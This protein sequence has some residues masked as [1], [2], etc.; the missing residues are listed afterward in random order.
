MSRNYLRLWVAVAGLVL[1]TSSAII[2][3]DKDRPKR[4]MPVNAKKA[5]DIDLDARKAVY[6]DDAYKWVY[7]S[8]KKG[9][10]G[11]WD[12]GKDGVEHVR[13]G[14]EIYVVGLQP[15]GES[16]NY[17][18]V[19]EQLAT[20]TYYFAFSKKP[21]DGTYAILY[22]VDDKNYFYWDEKGMRGTRV[23]P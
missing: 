19:K 13:F 11:S 9:G 3:D 17:Y 20:G 18:W 15:N 21:T 12:L 16:T 7:I 5:T 10:E 22:S 14:T 1:F 23:K 6:S 8:C 2:A 4:E